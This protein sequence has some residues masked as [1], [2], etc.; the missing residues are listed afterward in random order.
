VY[1]Q[2]NLSDESRETWFAKQKLLS[3]QLIDIAINEKRKEVQNLEEKLNAE[4][5]RLLFSLNQ[6][7]DRRALLLNLARKTD[8]ARE[9]FRRKRESKIDWLTNRVERIEPVCTE[10]VKKRRK[11]RFIKRSQYRRKQTTWN[12]RPITLIKNFSSYDFDE[13]TRS[14]IDR[15]PSFVPLPRSVNT[16]TVVAECKRFERKALWREFFYKDDAEKPEYVPPWYKPKIKI[17][18][19][20][21]RPPV[22][23]SECL[24][25]IRTEIL[26]TN[27][28]RVRNNLS[29]S[30]REAMDNLVQ[31]QKSGCITIQPCDKTGGLAIMDRVD[32]I[33]GM[34]DILFD[35]YIDPQTG[36]SN[37]CYEIVDH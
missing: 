12:A 22:P 20:P 16:T 25:S 11:R 31:L 9:T 6:D 7:C 8:S 37:P 14:L 29:N 34:N 5:R 17:N 26:S 19:P 4:K 30:E 21:A 2:P 18:L 1:H 23:L 28:N 13:A 36:Q 32:Y 27:L 33:A 24:S 10:S 35:T 15:G 3:F